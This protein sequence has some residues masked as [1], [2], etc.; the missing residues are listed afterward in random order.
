MTE[1]TQADRDAAESYYANGKMSAFDL[2]QA[3]ANHRKIDITDAMI[4]A[5]AAVELNAQAFKN[6]K[7]LATA[8]F[9]AMM[10]AHMDNGG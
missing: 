7:K 4:E 1:I 8:V 6:C 3:L 10:E 2:T 9:T 5:G